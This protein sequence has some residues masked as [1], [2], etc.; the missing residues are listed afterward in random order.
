MQIPVFVVNLKNSQARRE[1]IVKQL[2]D[3]G[4]SF[5]VFEAISG[6]EV[7]PGNLFLCNK[8]AEQGFGLLARRLL[9][10][11]FGCAL[12]H[13]KIF[14]KIVADRIDRACILEDDA[15]LSPDFSRI[16]NDDLLMRFRWGVI[17][18][19]HHGLLNRGNYH[20]GA[21]CTLPVQEIEGFLLSKPLELSNGTYAYIITRDAAFK[22]LQ[23][24]YPIRMPMDH[25]L[26]SAECLK[27][28]VFNVVPPVAIP[29]L[30]LE[31]TICDRNLPLSDYFVFSRLHHN[32]QII[33]NKIPLI[34]TTRLLI[35]DIYN[36]VLFS[37][38]RK[39]FFRYSYV[40][41]L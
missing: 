27:I 30:S 22:L 35:E 28:S 24:A 15:I 19:G 40:R 23:K 17:Y 12:S 1:R 39:G 3:L 9:N 18:L 29:D 38:R 4:I 26:G 31:S 2:D 25:F 14:E 21:A 36:R 13:L 16:L 34:K 10:N 33:K 41:K 37:L 8:K 11:E 20:V 6:N 5:R 32:F 7:D